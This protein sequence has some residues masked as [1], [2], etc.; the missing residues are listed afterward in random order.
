MNRRNH[1]GWSRTAWLTG[2]TVGA[3]VV[4]EALFEALLAASGVIGTGVRTDA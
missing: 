2:V 1:V 3:R 4:V